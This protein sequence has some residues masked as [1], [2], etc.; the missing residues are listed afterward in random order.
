[1]KLDKFYTVEPDA[2]C[3]VLNYEKVGPDKNDKGELI[4]SRNTSYH[5]NLKQ[6]LS[7]YLDNTL[8]PCSTVEAVI[9]RIDEVE[10]M[11]LTDVATVTWKQIADTYA[12]TIKE[13]VRN[14]KPK[15]AK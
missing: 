13:E 1:M 14:R 5:A 10:E 12:K 3:W 8:K 15:E 6:A 2:S 4:T 9:N 7:K 11:I